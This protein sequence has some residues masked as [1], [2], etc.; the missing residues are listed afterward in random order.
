MIK[1]GLVGV[2][3][4]FAELK[5]KVEEEGIT[6]IGAKCAEMMQELKDSTPVDTGNARDSWTLFKTRNVRMPFVVGN[7]TT[8]IQYLNAGSSKQAPSFFVD[9]IALRY[10]NP[11]GMVVTVKEDPAA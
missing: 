1:L 11:V 10:G 9:K 8:Y 7:T 6:K 5:E 3:R 2:A 4:T